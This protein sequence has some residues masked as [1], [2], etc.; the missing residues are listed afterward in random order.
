MEQ[1]KFTKP[2]F[3]FFLVL[4]SGISLGFVTVALPF[5]LTKNGFSV[6]LTA[7]IVAVGF[8]ANLW[9]F[10]WGPIVDISLSLRKWY[11]I[12]IAALIASLLLI[13]SIPLTIKGAAFISLIAFISQVAANITTLPV[14]GIIAKSIKES[15]KGEA[16]GWYQAGSLA[17]IGFGGGAGL[18]LAS[19]FTTITSGVA[20]SFVSLL[21]SFAIL[22]IKD[23]PHVK[24]NTIL[25]ELKM[26][27]KDI[28]SMIKMPAAVLV[29]VL[30]SVPIGVG[31]M[32]NL[33]SAVAND[34][35]VGVDTVVLVT[36]L[37]TGVV[38]AVGCVVGGLVLDKRGVWFGFFSF[39]SI[40]ALITLFIAI[41]PYRPAIYIIGVLAYGFSLGLMNAAF[42]AIIFFVIGKRHVAT[43]Y[44]LMSSLGN[45]P[46]V[47]MTTFDGWMHDKFNSRYMLLG[48][49]IVGI[50]FV[51]ICLLVL[52]RMRN[53]NLIPAI[54]E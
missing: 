25:H 44:S 6:A 30:I 31:A 32:S 48:E 51:I 53:K 34:W 7:G 1:Q 52:K 47:Y 29:M 38:S 22:L 12:S 8:S 37:L 49:A 16:S 42:T 15:K 4:P 14:N 10:V 9:R 46:V 24:E 36:G 54:V 39:G 11:W 50:C 45:L 17:G 35:K 3:V 26:M 40:C 33:W 5:L 13:C 18:W 41:M 20:L 28:F 23:I 2:F 27:G 43:K 21:F 19:H